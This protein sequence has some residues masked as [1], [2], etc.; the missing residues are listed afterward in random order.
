MGAISMKRKVSVILAVILLMTAAAFP[1]AADIYMPTDNGWQT[2]YRNFVMGKQYESAGMPDY[3]KDGYIV[4]AVREGT[5]Q[6]T[7][8]GQDSTPI[9]FAL[10]DMDGDRVPEMIVFNGID[11][12]GGDR[13]HVYT[14]LNGTLKRIGDMGF[15]SLQLMYSNDTRFPGLVQIDGS[16]GVTCTYYWYILSGV[17]RYETIQTVKQTS[18]G[19]SVTRNTLSGDL[20]NWCTASTLLELPHWDF[21]TIQSLGWDRFVETYTSR[22]QQGSYAVVTQAPRITWAP[23]P[24]QTPTPTQAAVVYGL[25]KGDLSTRSGPGTSYADMGTYSVRGQYLRVL[26]RAQDRSG[27]WWVKC[28][29]PYRNEIRVLWALYER[30]DRNSLPLESLPI[31]Q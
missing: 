17:P 1:G 20:Y 24:T 9:W 5:Y 14:Y 30:F 26:A 12:K 21:A 31:E 3:L 2:A 27:L 15:R 19:R 29:I 16:N 4:S 13:C 11:S 6:L 10:H 23:T 18:S 22:T 28:E 25:A 8:T 7:Y